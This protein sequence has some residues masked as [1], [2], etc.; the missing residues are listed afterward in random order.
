M[1]LP[2]LYSFRRCPYAMRAR[3]ALSVSGIA[4]EHRE[5]VLRDK[6]AALLLASAKGSVPVLVLADGQ[7][8]AE[9]WDIMLWALRYHDPNNWLGVNEC[10]VTDAM[11]LLQENDFV[12]KRALDRY[13]YPEKFP[14]QSQ[15]FYRAQGEEFLQQLQS[16]LSTHAYLLG[17]AITVADAALWPFVRQFAAV[18]AGWFGVAPYPQLRAWLKAFVAS[19]LFV[20]VMQKMPP[21]Q[22]NRQQQNG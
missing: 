21:W 20:Q 7:V 17:D 14:E 12:F 8:L 10:H 4:V 16:R 1:T 3:T 19:S 15:S 6:P 2:I 9:S 11:A 22:E 5:V 18:D 13:K